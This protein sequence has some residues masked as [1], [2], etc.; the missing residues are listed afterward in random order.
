MSAI[1]TTARPRPGP[2]FSGGGDPTPLIDRMP[3]HDLSAE[4]GVLGSMIIDPQVIGPVCMFLQRPEMFFKE[5]H[6]IIFRIIAELFEANTPFDGMIL[7][8]TLRTRNLLEQVGGTDYIKEL[9]HAVPTSAH[10]EYYAAIVKEKAMLRNLIRACTATLRDCYESGDPAAT[11]LDRGE[12]RIFEIAQQ[13]VSNQ[14]VPLT[15][16]LHETFEILERQSGEHFSGV[17]T[18]FI[19]LDNLT[20]GLQKGEM[21]V[22]AARP[23]VGKCLAFDSE[24]LTADGSLQ[25]IEEIYRQRQATLLTLHANFR[26]GMTEPSAFVD[27]GIKP[28][29]RVATRLGRRIE[30]TLAHPF[31]TV[32]GWRKLSELAP[33]DHVA[34][35]RKLDCFG[36]QRRPESEIKLLA[37]LIGDGCVTRSCPSFTNSNRTISADFLAAVNGFGGV[38]A[39]PSERRHGF[40]PSW[41]IVARED[42]R[43]QGRRAFAA[44]L[45]EQLHHH[46]MPARRLALAVGVKSHTVHYWLRGV[47]MP[48]AATVERVAA[49]LTIVPSCLAASPAAVQQKSA[50][51]VTRWLVRLGLAGK[52][53]GGKFIPPCVFQLPREQLALFLNRLFSTDGWATVLSGGNPQLGYAT[54][55]EKLARQIQHLL[56]RFGIVAALRKRAVLY[57]G[58]RRPSWQLDITDAR[59]IQTFARD[60]G[61][62]G[63]EPALERVLAQTRTRK[64]QTNVDL[65]PMEIWESLRR[66]KGHRSW[67]SVALQMG[68]SA[69]NSLHIGKRAP[70][71]ARLVQFAEAFDS[72][73]LRHLAGSDVFWDEIVAIEYVGE[74]QVFDLTIPETHNFV[75]NDICVHNTALA[76]N[77]IEHVGIDLKKPCA[78][79]SL[80]MSKQQLAQ[81]MLCSRSGVDS[82]KLRRGMLSHQDRDRLQYAVGDLS[83]G[84]VFI[85]DTPGLTLMD[86]RTKARRLKAQHNIE[87][88]ALDYLQ[89][90]ECPGKADNRQQEIATISRGVKALARELMIPVICL[91]Q[92]N[93]ASESE[94]RLPRT[95]DLRES[96]SIEQDADV[97]MLLHREAV[98][99]RGDQEWRDQN[100]DKLNEA[101]VIVAKQRNGP[102]D[103][104]KL[105]FLEGQTRFVN[106]NPGV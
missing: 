87:L 90:M 64:Y 86:L 49:A 33:G 27:D 39:V 34:V 31:L 94:Q 85:D 61:I 52:G 19:E 55:S 99:H 5:E 26:L 91:S 72:D 68:L 89:L 60:I 75:A 106:Y 83:S 3:P 80:E 79:F 38:H 6:Q 98:M 9:A 40:A 44:A 105:T 12:G 41:R 37:Y 36:S 29:F 65:I 67:R 77:I 35:P 93:R 76:M 101:L 50:N 18:G 62:I 42:L 28:V 24:I 71:R 104:V 102:C 56:L 22:I 30:T 66:L 69:D 13:K 15:E 70:S 96:G 14:A 10:A 103:N 20:S 82:H 23:S 17:A 74:K 53:A 4:A 57:R 46:R 58:T 32:S 11:V 8:S 47:S 2:G 54:V 59:S 73:E 78:M 7:H 16:V 21:I 43:R 1:P 25:T 51:S 84:S 100:P 63:K 95:S 48:D 81:R 45:A 88:L 92:L 97:V